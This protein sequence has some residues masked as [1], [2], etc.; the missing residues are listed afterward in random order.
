MDP[1]IERERWW[2]FCCHIIHPIIKGHAWCC[3]V[4]CQQVCFGKNGECNLLDTLCCP[5][6]KEDPVDP[7]P[8]KLYA[9]FQSLQKLIIYTKDV[10]VVLRCHLKVLYCNGNLID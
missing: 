1:S 2:D 3:S 9:G 7:L 6:C 10:P 8:H 4:W 5:A